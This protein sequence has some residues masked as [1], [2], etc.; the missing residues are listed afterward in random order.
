MASS[1]PQDA[2]ALQIRQEIA[3]T[4]MQIL[5]LNNYPSDDTLEMYRARFMRLV[6]CLTRQRELQAERAMAMAAAACCFALLNG[7]R[8]ARDLAL[9]EAET[10]LW[11]NTEDRRQYYDWLLWIYFMKRDYGRMALY[12]FRWWRAR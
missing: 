8:T 1:L 9:K 11:H 7:N 3:Q 2:A 4:M 10:A 5:D 12:L 6:T